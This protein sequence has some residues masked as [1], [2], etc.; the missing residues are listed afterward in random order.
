MGD[1]LH[2]ILNLNI[3]LVVLILRPVGPLLAR[4]GMNLE[5]SLHVGVGEANNVQ[6]AKNLILMVGNTTR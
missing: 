6:G 2:N 1:V 4:A 5:R 3:D